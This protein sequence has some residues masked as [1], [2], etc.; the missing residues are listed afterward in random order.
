LTAP[1]APGNYDVWVIADNFTNVH[2]QSDTTND[3]QH[4]AFTVAASTA[5][6]DLKPTNLSLGS[7]TVAPGASLSVSWLLANLGPGAADGTSTTELRINQS[8]TSFAGTNLAGVNTAALAGGTSASQ[9][10]TLTAPT[11]PGN[12]DVWVI[13]DNFTNVHN[14][15]DT[16]NDAQHIAFTVATANQAP[17]ISGPTSISRTVNQTISF[18]SLIGANDPDGSVAQYRFS[19]TTPGT[20]NGYLTLNG[21]HISGTSVTVAA[22]NLGNVGYFTGTVAGSNAIAIEAIDNLGLVSPDYLITTISIMGQQGPDTAGQTRATALELGA[23]ANGA[24]SLSEAVGANDLADYFRFEVTQAGDFQASLSALVADA[25]LFLLNANGGTLAQSRNSGVSSESVSYHLSPGTYYLDVDRYSGDTPYQ[26]QYGFTPTVTSTPSS[27]PTILLPFGFQNYPVTITQTY[28]D[29]DHNTDPTR[30]WFYYAVDFSL[31]QNTPVLSV[32]TGEVI[33]FRNDIYPRTDPKYVAS[34]DPS[35]IGNFVTIYYP[36]PSHPVDPQHL[37]GFFASY[38]HLE[39]G[40]V[41]VSKTD[42][43]QLGTVI[44]AVG[45]TGDSTGY[46]LHFQTGLSLHS[47]G[48][49]QYADASFSAQGPAVWFRDGINGLLSDGPAPESDNVP[50]TVGQHTV[51]SDRSYEMTAAEHDLVLTGADSVNAL[52]NDS[53]N[54]IVGNDGNNRIEALGGDDVV[55]AG[56]GDDILVGGSGAGNDTYDG[57]DGVD[58]VVYSSATLGIVV[59]LSLAQNQAVGVEIGTDQISNI[60]NVIGG[61]GNDAITG[62]AV[63]NVLIG[64]PGND[65][66]IG[67]AGNDMAVYSAVVGTYTLLSYNGTLAVLTHGADGDDRLQGV[68]TLQFSD[69]LYAAS[70]AAAFDP[71]EYIASHGDLIQAFGANPQAGFDHYVDSG[72]TEGRSTNLFDA[73]EYIASNPDLIQAFGLNP[74][75]GEQHYVGSGF[76]EHRA[77]NSFDAT[78]YI[79]SYADLIQAFGLNPLAGEQHYITSGFKEHRATNLFD[80]VEYIASNGDLIQAFGL[81]PLAGEQHYVASGFNEHRAISSFDALEYIASNAD[82]IQ[83][84]GLNL[85]VAR[86]QYILSGFAE[87]RP[88]HSFDAVE[89]IAS[90]ADLITAFGLNPLVGEQQYILSGFKEHRSTNSFDAIEYIASNTDLIKA[91]GLNALAGEQHYITNGFNE[92][93][94]TN[95][96]DAAEYIASN[97]DLIQAFGFNPV[98]GEQHYIASGF[99]EHRATSSFDALDYIASNA[100]LIQAFGL[101]LAVARQH[102]I[103]SGFN[104]HRATNSFDAIEYI[105]SNGDLIQAFGVNA[106]AGEQ[107]YIISGFGEHRATNSFDAAQYLAN[108]ADLSAAFGNN[109]AA[110]ER[111]Y[112]TNGFS[113]GRSDKAPVVTGDGGNNTLVAANGAIMTGGAGA[114]N[115]AFNVLLSKPATITDFA[116]GTDHLQ[117]SASGFGHGLVAGGAAPLVAAATA[118]GA[119]HAGPDGYFIF[120]NAGTVWWDPNGG[121]GADAMALAKLSGIAALHA[122]DFL[123]A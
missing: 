84:F 41:T 50:T 77:T 9:S 92:H 60:E 108:Y 74:L 99:G 58:T 123:L 62:N 12:Y 91:F 71:W 104:E 83:A 88:T 39:R 94:A 117:I 6:S 120:D 116:A 43:V 65:R 119:S 42:T 68:E 111:H 90:N 93:R 87:H 4:I 38:F 57:G 34:S 13:A 103:A 25:D 56:R 72:F 44:G 82:L 15:S 114:D 2:N 8:S 33:D 14:Q 23:L 81:N 48:T 31:H 121:G 96:F 46:H 118:A 1:T 32:G 59:N 55:F 89:Y 26:L 79:A 69:T 66:L 21:S 122:S 17:T 24:H 30:P 10:T 76:N 64:G 40:S 98:A 5:Q 100:D 107:H 78:E 70:A 29:G 52:G 63:D 67:G 86:Q 80:P 61:S 18:T 97:S 45:T 54:S 37:Y 7:T 115:F 35:G 106:V 11:A 113:E 20:D 102:Y 73:V 51:Q 110:A 28:G 85:A 3:A 19:D 36:D 16:T 101:N 47:G 27:H 112:I 49:G 22:S 75:A 109:L 53:P 105:A 95:S